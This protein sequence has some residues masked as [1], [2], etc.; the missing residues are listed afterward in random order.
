MTLELILRNC[1][2]APVFFDRQ[3]KNHVRDAISWKGLY[4]MSQGA[5][6]FKA[7]RTPD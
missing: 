1:E 2:I 6:H 7:F 4:E 3:A 5:P